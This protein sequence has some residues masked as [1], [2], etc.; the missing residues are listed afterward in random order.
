MITLCLLLTGCAGTENTMQPALDLRAALLEAGGCTFTAEVTADFGE[1]VFSYAAQCLYDGTQTR[2]T[3]TAPEALAG[4]G[5]TVAEDGVSVEFDGIV[6]ELGTLAGGHLAPLSATA[7]LCRC[8]AREYISSAGTADG[9]TIVTYLHGYD[10][11]E[12]TVETTISPDG[13]P[14]SGE[15]AADGRTAAFVTITDFTYLT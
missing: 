14:I 8:W 2:L 5:A 11:A 1:T 7:L 6:L 10:E 9:G 15:I 12:F 3:L 4:V 13:A